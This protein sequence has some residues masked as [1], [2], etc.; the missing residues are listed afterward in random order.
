MAHV[1]GSLGIES[2][3]N[4]GRGSGKAGWC[5]LAAALLRAK[6]TPSRRF[7]VFSGALCPL[8]DTPA[9]MNMTAFWCSDQGGALQDPPFKRTRLL[10]LSPPRSRGWLLSS[11]ISP[12]LLTRS[13][14]GKLR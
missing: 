1:L 13:Q 12:G 14:S 2:R 5:G 8:L 9:G 10:P 7:H 6:Q 11:P 4:D 3:S